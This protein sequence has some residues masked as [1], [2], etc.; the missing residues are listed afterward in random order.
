MTR[1]RLLLLLLLCGCIQPAW[2]NRVSSEPRF[3][4]SIYSLPAFHHQA[5]EGT[6]T[7]AQLQVYARREAEALRSRDPEVYGI[8]QG[9]VIELTDRWVEQMLRE[10]PIDAEQLAEFQARVDRA[11]GLLAE[12]FSQRG[13]SY[14]PLKV[15]L[16]PRHVFND[17]RHRRKWFDGFTLDYYPDT[18]FV[19]VDPKAPVSVALVHQTLRINR[20]PGEDRLNLG[21]SF[22][23]GI[24][25]CLARRLVETHELE[26]KKALRR[27]EVYADDRVRVEKVLEAMTT[28]GGLGRDEAIHR[29]VACYLTGDPS[30][31]IETFG[32]DRWDRLVELSYN[33][34]DWYPSPI[35]K[36]LR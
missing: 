30:Q 21:R 33:K 14:Q 15:V 23:M 25:E 2:S 17:P 9:H 13:W 18:Y 7:S 3:P 5:L 35:E 26:S 1:R 19:G 29:L 11:Q 24:A 28:R 4:R 8:V 12:L 36:L 27:S 20:V 22:Q 34:R 16:V 32:R 10:H 31:M 6:L